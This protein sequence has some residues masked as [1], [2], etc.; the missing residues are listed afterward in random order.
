MFVTTRRPNLGV[1]TVEE[2]ALGGWVARFPRRWNFVL[3]CIDGL[4]ERA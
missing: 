3:V 1:E 2:P 4:Q